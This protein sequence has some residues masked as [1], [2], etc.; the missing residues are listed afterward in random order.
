MRRFGTV[1]TKPPLRWNS[2]RN[3][4]EYPDDTK[5]SAGTK[6]LPRHGAGAGI[7]RPHR[8][9]RD[10]HGRRNRRQI[11]RRTERSR[12]ARAQRMP[13]KAFRRTGQNRASHPHRIR[14]ETPVAS[15]R[16][17]Q[18]PLMLASK[19]VVSQHPSALEGAIQVRLDENRIVCW[20]EICEGFEDYL[21]WNT[22]CSESGNQQ[23][24]TAFATKFPAERRRIKVSK[25]INHVLLS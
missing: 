19:Q 12:P 11:F 9:E 5:K 10:A 17:I 21:H 6:R 1:K 14:Q 16:S 23:N 7:A 25:R 4:I 13:C 24:S 22:V 20:R 18:V 8:R 2:H 15:A 3:L